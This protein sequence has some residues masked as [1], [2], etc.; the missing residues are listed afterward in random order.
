MYLKHSDFDKNVTITVGP[1]SQMPSSHLIDIKEVIKTA[2]NLLTLPDI[3]LQLKRVV[4]DPN[5]SSSD[6]AA[7]II[8]DQAL[9]A[10]LLK[11]V[12]SSIYS[13]PRKISQVSEAIT[14]IGTTQLYNLALA[15]TAATIIR[16]AGGSHIELKTLWKQAVYTA[17]LTQ[18]VYPADAK[19]NDSLFIAGLLCNIGTL[20]VVEY[21]PEIAMSAIGVTNSGQYPWQREKEVFGFTVAE[22]SGS[23]LDA[24]NLPEEIVEPV[25]FQHQPDKKSAHFRTSCALHIA[26]RLAP[27]MLQGQA[28]SCNYRDAIGQDTLVELSVEDIETVMVKAHE[29][30]PEMLAIYTI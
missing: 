10:R 16:T 7:L 5:S 22:V 20:V 12:N 14:L 23:L 27:E 29:I 11:L 13:F 28:E 1:L 19:D 6:F 24:W 15:T 2:G 3:C 17:I 9:T 25:R 26:T 30:A 8:K 21:S 18:A 4:D